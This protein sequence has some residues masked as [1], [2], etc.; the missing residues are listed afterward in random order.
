MTTT[1][2]ASRVVAGAPAV[3]LLLLTSPEAAEFLPHTKLTSTA[4]GQVRGVLQIA[5]GDER[6][7]EVVT[8]PPRRTPTAYVSEFEV[9]VEGAPATRGALHVTSAGP[10]RSQV[11]FTL[12]A[13]DEMPQVLDR[14]FENVTSGFLDGLERAANEQNRAA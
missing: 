6:T 12:T 8:F 10:N 14:F 1:L 11:S 2:T 13:Q 4:P 9:Q 7:L 3:A 5:E